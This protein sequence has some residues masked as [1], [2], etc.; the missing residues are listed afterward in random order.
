M[1]VGCGAEA[2]S[3]DSEVWVGGVG[4][5]GAEARCLPGIVIS[6][7]IEVQDELKLRPTRQENS[8]RKEDPKTHLRKPRVGH[9]IDAVTQSVGRE[10]KSTARNGCATEE[11]L[12]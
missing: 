7:P 5:A 2:V 4:E 11:N 9:L 12:G 10:P 6:E 3:V 1:G 8:K